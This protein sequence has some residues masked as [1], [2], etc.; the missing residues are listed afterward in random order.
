MIV[1]SSLLLACGGDGGAVTAPTVPLAYTRFVHAVADTSG[2]DWRFIDQIENSPVAFGL[3]FRGSTPYQA[4][5]PGQRHLRV[6]PTT[7]DINLAPKF[8]ID[9]VLTLEND[10]YYT[11]VHV[12]FARAGQS[13]GQKIL[14][15]KDEIPTVAD[16]KIAIRVVHLGTGLGSVDVYADTL[17][18]SSPLPATVLFSNVALSSTRGYAMQD[19]GR[20]ALRATNTGQTTPVV[21]SGVAPAGEAG[22]ASQNLTAIGGSRMGKSVVT[23]FLFPRSVA[24]SSAPQTAAFTSPVLTFL[25]DRHPR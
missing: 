1:A 4:T 9:T 10:T 12:G 8:L 15:L 24:G 25:I 13:P 22:N 11:I 21:A 14:V 16:N 19:T 3:T 2:T 20:L 18:G 23:A 7:T 17:G 6:F 5:A